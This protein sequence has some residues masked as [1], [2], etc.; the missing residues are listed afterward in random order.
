MET[1][2]D[3]APRSAFDPADGVF[4]AQLRRPADLRDVSF[5][6]LSPLLRALLV[7]DGTVTK[8]LEAYALEPITVR[9]L[10][11]FSRILDTDD[12]WLRAAAGE[13]IIVRHVM[14]VGGESGRLYTYAESLIVPSRLS[15]QM[16]GR[17]ETESGG[18]GKIL[19]DSA[20]ETR[21]E[22]LWYGR[23]QLADLPGPVGELCDGDFLLR[24]YRIIAGGA[25]LMR[26]TERFPM[27]SNSVASFG[28]APG[29]A[30]HP[31]S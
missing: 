8:F 1:E 27:P 3:Y 30:R 7:I 29:Q 19:L 4:V 12:P 28:R 18:L 15:L 25:P 31:G 11:Q 5:E 17:L 21:R 26:I 16:Q 24:S 9:R 20:L 2:Q 14:L 22:G 10:G 6:T 23:E 13:R